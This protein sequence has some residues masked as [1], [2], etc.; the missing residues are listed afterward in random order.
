M[1][2]ITR[3]D[4]SGALRESQEMLAVNACS[5]GGL[6]DRWADRIV[7]GQSRKGKNLLS[8]STGNQ[9]ALGCQ[10][11]PAPDFVARRR[12]GGGSVT[13]NPPCLVKPIISGGGKPVVAA[14]MDDRCHQSD[15]GTAGR[16]S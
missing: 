3:N 5:V 9:S 14:S 16:G 15:S 2:H 11:T 10:I 4:Y 8:A 1:F 12:E 13:F 7:S 6:F